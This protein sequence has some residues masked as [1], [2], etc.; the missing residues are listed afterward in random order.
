MPELGAEML[1]PQTRKKGGTDPNA[2]PA[3][4]AHERRAL[5]GAERRM[6]AASPRTSRSRGA[7]GVRASLFATVLV[8]ETGG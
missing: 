1:S 4:S 6:K 5:E 8:L 3:R 2:E 7:A